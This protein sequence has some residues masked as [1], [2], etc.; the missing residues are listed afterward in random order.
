MATW[1]PYGADVLHPAT[2][3]FGLERVSAPAPAVIVAGNDE[4]GAL[5]CELE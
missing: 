3:R 5:W 1:A 4:V 2:P